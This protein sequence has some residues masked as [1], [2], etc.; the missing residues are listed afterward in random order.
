MNYYTVISSDYLAHHGILGQKWGHKNGPPYPLASSQKSSTEKQKARKRASSMTDEELRSAIN[1]KRLE[2]RY[3]DLESRKKKDSE[4]GNTEAVKRS[5]LSVG[6]VSKALGVDEVRTLAEGTT[7]ILD[8]KQNV[9][10]SLK[11]HEKRKNV[12][13][14]SDEELRKTVDRMAL[15]QEY[16]D[17]NSKEF[18]T[19]AQ[20]VAD[21]METAG[22][23]VILTA[24]AIMTAKKVYKILSMSGVFLKDT[25]VKV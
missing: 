10:K 23:A 8:Q 17:T 2:D 16:V 11:K 13:Q 24:G 21:Y 1:R 3:N 5:V 18:K 25:P 19:G 9:D 22:N 14:M 20:K 4:T 6:K 15:E 12:S 7:K